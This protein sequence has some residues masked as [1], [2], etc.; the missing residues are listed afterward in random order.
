MKSDGFNCA[1]K[2]HALMFEPDNWHG[3]AMISAYKTA[4]STYFRGMTG[5]AFVAMV[6]I[7]MF[8]AAGC[9]AV[10]DILRSKYQPQPRWLQALARKTSTLIGA[11]RRSRQNL[12]TANLSFPAGQFTAMKKRIC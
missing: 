2:V 6:S 8:A 9:A 12:A 10:V 4:S 5:T 11:P 7:W 1:F 3:G